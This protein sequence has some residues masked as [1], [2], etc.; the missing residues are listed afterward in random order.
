MGFAQSERI[1]QTIGM[2]YLSLC[3]L[4]LT[5]QGTYRIF[6]ETAIGD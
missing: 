5:P 2:F 6:Y 3:L 4:Y 1:T